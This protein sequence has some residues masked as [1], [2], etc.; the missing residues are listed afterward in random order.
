MAELIRIYEEKAQVLGR[1]E[2]STDELEHLPRHLRATAR[3]YIAGM[4]CA[5]QLSRA[6]FYRHRREL[7][8]FGLDIAVRNVRAFQPR[9][10][11]ITLRPAVAPSWYRMAA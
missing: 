1:A 5:A 6:T 8:S 3:D 9:V 7:L 10:Q 2:R 11:V 4:D